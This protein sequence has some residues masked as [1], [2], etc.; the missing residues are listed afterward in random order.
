[1]YFRIVG[2]KIQ[3][4]DDNGLPAVGYEVHTYT[5]GTSTATAS[6]SERTLTTPN[7]NPIILD[8]RGEADIYTGV[9]LK[10]IFTI[11]GGDPTSPIWSVD[12]IGEQ[13]ENRVIGTV[14]PTTLN[15]NYVVTSTPAVTALTENF[16]LTITPDVT[17]LDTINPYGV[18]PFT[19]T[20][21]NDLTASGPYIGTV[22]ATF[23][24]KID[25]TIVAAPVAP[26]VAENVTAGLVTTGNHYVKLTAVTA[27]GETVPGPAS[28]V[29][30]SAGSKQIDVSG[31]PAVADQVTGYKVYMTKAGGTAY[32]YVATVTATTYT[33]N[34]ADAS[35][36][37]LAPTTDTTGIHDT[38]TWKKD[39]G[40]WHPGV[41]ITAVAQI[42]QE[43]FTVTF[44]TTTGHTY[45]DL[46]A[47]P[48]ITPARVDLDGTGNNLVYK[49]KNKVAVPIDGG[50]MLA[51]YPAQFL[52]NSAL[53]GWL[54]VNPATPTFSTSTIS[55]IRYRKDI[56]A[57]YALLFDD[58]GREL[59]CTAALTLTLL[60]PP[61]FAN[62][63]VYIGN[64][65]TG[66][67]TVDAGASYKIYPGGTRYWYLGPGS[68]FQFQTNG[69]DWHV[70]TS[71]GFP[72][73]LSQVDVTAGSV[74]EFT[75]LHPGI[76][77]RI[78]YEMLPA[79]NIDL[80]LTFND[81]SSNYKG[82]LNYTDDSGVTVGSTILATH[83]PVSTTGVGYYSW[84]QIDFST[85]VGDDTFVQVNGTSHFQSAADKILM[86]L[87]H[88]VYAGTPTAVTKATLTA[89][90]SAFT[91]TVRLYQIG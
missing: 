61:A 44:A 70:M 39:G 17:N 13:Q 29:V 30:A 59:N 15:N 4:F 75:D 32:Y 14:V 9:A 87:F 64:V 82:V 62:R 88:G 76:K 50:D 40:V 22:A 83:I 72:L 6:Y 2:A 34:V 47:V 11:P 86:G 63:F 57:D 26:T 48:V 54:L 10:L 25:G 19:G 53:T 37:V 68:R 23:T 78:E 74:A 58:Q 90:I 56:A 84:G 33:I 66:M 80:D 49:N 36:T 89:T 20:G 69:V 1:M 31:I 27:V 3:L 71:L 8:A 24:I 52:V 60:S 7:T 67:V 18:N 73:L 12:Y 21:S 81:D 43:G 45:D 85:I 79:G 91:G 55:A 28:G 46:W 42:L 5:A 51:G 35:L 77:Y 16:E 65:G 38:F 41:P